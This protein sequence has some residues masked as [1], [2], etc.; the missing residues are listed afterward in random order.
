MTTVAEDSPNRRGWRALLLNGI[1]G[2]GGLS[3]LI[4]AA[5]VNL[6]GFLFHLVMSRN[7]GPAYYGEL[8]SLLNIITVLAVP[9]GALQ[10][11]VTQAVVKQF[12]VG[13]PRSLRRLVGL[14]LVG[15]T[16]AMLVL[17]ATIPLLDRFLHLT[18]PVPL[19]LVGAWIP[20]A[21]AS[22]VLQGALLGEYRF[23]IVAVASF[24]GGGAARLAF[25]V[26]L[27]AAGLGV[28]G[29][30]EATILGQ[31]LTLGVLALG[32][33]KELFTGNA[34]V[35]VSVRDALLSIA[36]IGGYTA[37]T[38]ADTLFAR[39]FF[40]ATLAGD[41]AA[42][43]TAAHIALFLP[44]TLVTVVFPRLAEGGGTDS[45]SRR[46]FGEALSLTL[47]LGLAAVA[48]IAALPGFVVRV[49]FGARYLP[50]AGIVGLLSLE[51]AILGIAVLLVY[52]HVARG[53]L[54]ALWPWGA[55]LAAGAAMIADHRTVKSIVL[56]MVVASLL[57]A[58][59]LGVSAI[60][61]LLRALAAENKLPQALT[62]ANEPTLDV[63]LVVPFYN[64]G[65]GLRYHVAE[66]AAALDQARITFEILAVSDG[67][68]DG[69]EAQL[70]GLL[71]DLVRTVVLP[72]NVGK[73]AALRVGLSQ[74]RGRYL[75]FIDADGDI[76]A[77]LLGQFVDVIV[78]D[79]PELVVGSKRHPH[80]QVVYPTARRV[81]SIG[82]QWLNWILFR[83]PVRDT[84]TGVKIIR[85]DV[86]T[87]VIP[88]M[89][90]KR[91][92]F[93]LE[94]LVVARRLG[95]RQVVEL[96]VV[97]RDR[98]RSTIS[99]RA[100]FSMLVDT[101]AIFYRLRVL[102]HYGPKLAEPAQSSKTEECLQ[103]VRRDMPVLS[104]Q[105]TGG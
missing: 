4:A 93:D 18:S 15:G 55:L 105:H 14:S 41:Y 67:S 100:V 22:A 71:P 12:D 1:L 42:A 17:C 70:A 95:Y 30:V 10:L 40:P 97:I 26:A 20:L 44:A 82:Y 13:G 53:S 47:I 43:S 28:Q 3:F 87:A 11:T 52:F 66:V 63:S 29:A 51:S 54:V 73:G 64:P 32:A 91:F 62:G 98:F 77:R 2:R 96:P 92:A 102:K 94:L 5:G 39:H 7:L 88:R 69:S 86:L 9:I 48:A 59:V 83:L 60:G 72:R 104:L 78:R 58:V 76:P 101:A 89:V 16:V 8:G 84:Q 46:A 34:S 27:G 50:A 61:A 31:L 23:G 38:G 79:R 85:R 21:A 25:G 68:T 49:L 99:G 80:S 74:G 45:H 6:S 75:G 81:Y 33:R 56:L 57:L 19:I 103:I 90:E 35:R 24:G 65:N 36:A 37:M